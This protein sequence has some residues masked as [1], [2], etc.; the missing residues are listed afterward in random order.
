MGVIGGSSACATNVISDSR[1]MNKKQNPSKKQRE[2]IPL[3]I[4]ISIGLA[5]RSAELATA[6]D[7]IKQADKALYKAKKS[8]RN[9][10]AV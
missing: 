4:T 6:D 9:Q 8:G 5:E 1:P 7:V 2:A 3:T 10:V